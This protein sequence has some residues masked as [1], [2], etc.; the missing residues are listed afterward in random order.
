MTKTLVGPQLR[1]LRRSYNQTQAEMARN[2]NVSASYVNLLENNQ[3]SLSVKVLLALTESY[4]VD[5]RALVNDHSA[6]QLAD[7]RA[8]VRDP[9]LST[10]RPDLQELR[11]ALDH[12]PRLVAQFLELHQNH[13]AM[14]GNL[15]HM[16]QPGARSD[17]LATSAEAAIHDFFRQNSNHFPALEAAADTA[18]NAIG[19]ARDD[20]YANLKMYLHDR[21]HIDVAVKSYDEMP[22]TLRI[23][24]RKRGVVT[25][26]EM[27]DPINRCFQLAHIVALVSCAHLL[28]DLVATFGP[29]SE[30]GRA[31]CRVELANYFAAAVL[32]PYDP[33]LSQAASCRYDVDRIAAA[34][35]VTFEMACQR[36]TT[37]QRQGAQGVPFFFL[38][39]D[40]AGN[41]T[42]RF[43]ATPF[44]L[45]E[46]GG[47]CPV[48][49][50]HT[51]FAAP[52]TIVTQFVELPD[53]GQFF[54]FSR[55]T[56]RPR[57]DRRT[58]HRRL[59]VALGCERAH[60]KRVG[61]ADPFD[62]SDET[63]IAKIGINCHICPRQACAQRAHEPLHVHLPVD[64][65]RR[66]STRY[67][68]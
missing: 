30:A 42:K 55:T 9:A 33:F 32:M 6:T 5:W 38:R 52:G 64:A 12:A 45:A 39:I 3:R 67:E 27:L 46:Q 47:S 34:F 48:W 16:H 41:V 26:S 10:D 29:A 65:N 28:D 11:A 24:D 59:V 56:D 49:N 35:G 60:V 57:M 37:L 18:R 21:Y 68:S 50:I 17:L 14:L 36:L 54:T 20:I 31:R 66:G 8:A 25:L 44:T 13:R 22:D 58:A 61:Y 4:G 51:A 40:E 43:N 62:L 53:S 15:Q 23:F 7:L 1:Q 63:Q 19:G 2:L